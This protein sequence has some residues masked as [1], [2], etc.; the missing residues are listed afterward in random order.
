MGQKIN[1]PIIPSST[2]NQ[3]KVVAQIGGI[4]SKGIFRFITSDG[5][6]Y[7]AKATG[8]M[9]NELFAL[10]GE[11]LTLT[12]EGKRGQQMTLKTIH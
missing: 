7:S 9:L 4:D 8:D 12:L 10:E 1:I 3:L 11:R 5:S 6:S 2:P